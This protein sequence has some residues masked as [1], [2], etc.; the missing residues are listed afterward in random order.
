MTVGTLP[1]CLQ[2]FRDVSIRKA[3]TPLFFPVSS[4]AG[5]T[6]DLYVLFILA[7]LPGSGPCVLAEDSTDQKSRTKGPSS[8]VFLPHTS[9]VL[10]VL[11]FLEE[12]YY[13]REYNPICVV[14]QA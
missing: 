8:T 13:M 14:F 10:Y 9:L 3:P 5:T 6:F 11:L 7:I 4:A 1:L 2:G 12:L